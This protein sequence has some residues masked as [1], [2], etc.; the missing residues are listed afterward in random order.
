MKK[1]VISI[2]LIAFFCMAG[3]I[4]I[5]FHI[6]NRRKN[7]SLFIN[8][9]LIEEYSPQIIGNHVC[10][11]VIEVFKAYGY[12]VEIDEEK[13]ILERNALRLILSSK[14]QTMLLEGS[15]FNLLSFPPGTRNGYRVFKNNDVNVDDDLLRSIFGWLGEDIVIQNEDDGIHI[16]NITF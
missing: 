1:K 3:I 2:A 13:A 10:F 15:D 7:V 4:L 12:S 14:K 5:C 11:S 9:K 16:N 6:S 8:N